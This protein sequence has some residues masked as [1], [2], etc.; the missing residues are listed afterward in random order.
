[1]IAFIVA[2]PLELFNSLMIM[3]HHFSGDK[4]DLFVLDIACDMRPVIEKCREESQID[5]VYFLDD[6]CK[7]PSRIGTIYDHV[8]LTGKQRKF[9]NV[10][11]DKEYTDLF[12]T[13]VGSPA[14]W[15]FTK[16]K[17]RNP[18][19][20]LHFYEEGTGVYLRK[21]CL[22]YHG[23]KFL[24]KILGYFCESDYIEDIY[25]YAP[26]LAQITSDVCLK[27]IGCA[28]QNDIE[29]FAYLKKD[30]I[31]YS[32]KVLF[33]ENNF[34]SLPE[35]NV[36]EEQ[37]LDIIS[38]IISKEQIKVRLHPR[39]RENNYTTLGYSVDGNKSVPWE[40]IVGFKDV[41]GDLILISTISTAVF[42]PKLI[43][44]YEPRVVLLGNLIDN[45]RELFSASGQFWSEKF[46][47]LAFNFSELYSDQS[48]ISI[49]GSVEE[50]LDVLKKWM[51]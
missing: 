41:I 48:R 35:Y 5:D 11:R 31:P 18:K 44:G 3:H 38:K 27:S 7:R 29:N 23:I 43:Y 10:I 22:D 1:M 24:Y 19:L 13:W 51:N 40:N 20:H 2:T 42:T 30:I 50:L 6:I 8:H 47:N 37:L 21:I 33:L 45:E 4:V 39:T 28:N 9:L 26:Q 25:M 46:R 49:P 16:I 17:K 14:T 34:Y 36:N 32:E 15:I 12:S